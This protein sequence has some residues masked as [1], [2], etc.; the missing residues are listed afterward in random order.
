NSDDQTV[1]ALAVICQALASA[2]RPAA[3]YEEWGVIAAPNLFG[4]S[5]TY[6][7]LLNFRADGAWGISPHMIPH[8]SL[9]AVSGTI[10][11]ALRMHGP[12]FGISGGPNAAAEA[13]LVAAT[14]LSNNSVPGLWVVMTGHEPEW[15]PGEVRQ[16]KGDDGMCLA[17][18]LAL[19]PA[20]ATGRSCLFVS[21][22]TQKDDATF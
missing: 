15:L 12:N 20:G 19:E 8:H 11:Q 10:S 7:A 21:P 3:Y 14:L 2:Q 5:G 18:A 13:F 17:A 16:D 22:R 6:Q 1:L 9:H 4:R